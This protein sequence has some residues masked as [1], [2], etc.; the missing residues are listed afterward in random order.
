MIFI[1][2][3]IS[4]CAETKVPA[5][6]G[7]ETVTSAETSVSTVPVDESAPAETTAADYK[8]AEELNAYYS[9]QEERDG[10]ICDALYY[11][12]EDNVKLA[13]LRC[14]GKL[15]ACCSEPVETCGWTYMYMDDLPLDDGELG[16]LTADVVFESGGEDG[17]CNVPNIRRQIS[18]EKTDTAHFLE[19]R[20]L[21][22]WT[23][24]DSWKNNMM[25]FADG[26]KTY[27]IARFSG[28]VPIETADGSRKYEQYN[29][30]FV[31]LDGKTVG[32][33]AY[34]KYTLKD[35]VRLISGET[36]EN[37][38]Y[39][40]KIMDRNSFL[41]F[42]CGD[43]YYFFGKSAS[44]NSFPTILYNTRFENKLPGGYE[45][46]DGGCAFVCADI[47][48][49]NGN[50]LVNAPMIS[51]ISLF[52]ECGYDRLTMEIPISPVPDYYARCEYDFKNVMFD[53]NMA[54]TW[55]VIVSDGRYE[56]FLES[57]TDGVTSRE[58]V[59]TADSLEEAKCFIDQKGNVR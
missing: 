5:S 38:G 31:F 23:E 7:K 50:E 21:P 35:V 19:F 25:T 24:G 48:L 12:A 47:K 45:L 29:S 34:D 1:C 4:G 20:E 32:E 18:F 13:I 10:N 2:A 46:N 15:Y 58:H 16:F 3:A 17:R 56:L 40:T 37:A 26:D 44:M 36:L 33:Y 41:V 54:G 14:K 53:R 55:L 49:L 8:S 27:L 59:G 9:E 39:D 6:G 22:Y 11:H 51:E 43:E 52:E 42:R 30:W 28:G 57:F